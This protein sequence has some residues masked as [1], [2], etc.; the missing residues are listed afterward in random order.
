MQ[1]SFSTK[2]LSEEEFQ[3]AYNDIMAFLNFLSSHRVQSK[4]AK[5]TK[6]DLYYKFASGALERRQDLSKIFVGFYKFFFTYKYKLSSSSDLL[7]LPLGTSIEYGNSGQVFLELQKFI[8]NNKSNTQ[9]LDECYN[10]LKKIEAYMDTPTIPGLEEYP[11]IDVC[12]REIFSDINEL[13]KGNKTKN[14]TQDDFSKL[15]K[16]GVLTRLAAKLKELVVAKKLDPKALMNTVLAKVSQ[17]NP[18]LASRIEKELNGNF[19]M[20]QEEAKDLLEELGE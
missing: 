4:K 10:Y 2:E 6:F 19:P 20:S 17:L 11:E 3:H 18:E 8:H 13:M 12:V 1:N 7:N 5:K 15:I 14:I 16:S 9:F